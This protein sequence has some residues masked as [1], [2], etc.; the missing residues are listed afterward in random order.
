[1]PRQVVLRHARSGLVAATVLLALLGPG[2]VCALAASPS[3][4]PEPGAASGSVGNQVVLVG[5]VVVPRGQSVGEV[6]VFSGRV[7]IQGLVRG[8]V[9]VF[10]GSV[11][12][13]G[14]VSGSVIALS[15][16]IHLQSTAQVGG[17]V[18]GHDRVVIQPG[19]L[20]EGTVREHVAF[21]L[22]RP[23]AA[24]G[25]LL[26]W[27]AVSVS[28]LVLGLGL[29]LVSPRA[30]DRVALA[31]RTAP[32]G[33]AG[34]GVLLALVIPT[35]SIVATASIVGLPAGLTLLL[36]TAFLA[37]LSFVLAVYAVGRAVAG[38]DR[39]PI[40]A[41]LAGWGIATVAGVVPYLNAVA[42]TA[43]A[44]YGLG[45][46]SVAIW[47]TRGVRGRHRRGYAAPAEEAPPAHPLV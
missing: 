7:L 45:A 19:A 43:A 5:R 15:G 18:L 31:A 12:I 40:L 1:M 30:A 27:V 25:S 35:V 34:W 14:Q 16:P 36:A 20:A 28:T 6:V 9:V 33:S 4:S 10:D 3:P 11:T 17:D 44:M 38:P 21:S 29:I 42:W 39:P 13:E 37:F 41:L 2:A 46:A 24:L 23:L 26:S 32:W 47:R 22:R 8:D